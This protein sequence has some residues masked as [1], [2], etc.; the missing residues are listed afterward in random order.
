MRRLPW[1]SLVRLDRRALLTVVGVSLGIAFT[2]LGFAITGSLADGAQVLPESARLDEVV[3]YRD[4]PFAFVAADW[5]TDA[6]GVSVHPSPEGEWVASLVGAGAPDVAP[7]Q[8]RPA[9]APR[10]DVGATIVLDETSYTVGA[11][12]SHA[13]LGT[14]WWLV[15]AP[16]E[17]DDIDVR[18]DYVVAADPGAAARADWRAAGYQVDAAPQAERFFQASAREVA[19]DLVFVVAFS[20]LLVGVFSYEF[21]RGEVAAK[22]R[23]LGVWRAV[24]LRGRDVLLLV[25]ARAAVVSSA[26]TLL[27]LATAAGLLVAAHRRTGLALFDATPSAGTSLALG[28]IFVAAGLLGAFVPA[29]QAAARPVRESLEA[30]V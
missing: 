24:G 28:V 9:G 16:E 23:E 2:A 19:R 27:G 21:M 30:L 11:V 12:A 1:R 4:E 10:Q 17:P 7:G 8:A 13:R 22:R 29:R 14:S 25:L 5:P 6:W 3:A 26:G 20:A 18:V 15:V